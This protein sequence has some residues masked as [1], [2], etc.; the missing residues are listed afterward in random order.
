MKSTDSEHERKRLAEVYSGMADGEL[1]QL[2]EEPESLTEVA[3]QALQ[4]EMSRRGLVL[5]DADSHDSADEPGDDTG[6]SAGAA[7]DSEPANMVT[8]CS[9]TGEAGLQAALKARALLQAA[10]IESFLDVFVDVKPEDAEA[11]QNALRLGSPTIP[12]I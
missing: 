8:V 2:A 9:F 3:R 7:D 5:V 1:E 10:G 12:G 11:A 4:E 6:D